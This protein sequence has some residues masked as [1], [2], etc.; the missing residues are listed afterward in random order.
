MVN[1]DHVPHAK[2]KRVGVYGAAGHTAKLVA[3][4]LLRRGLTPVLG[5]RD[6]ARLAAA[7]RELQDAE[8]R[9]AHVERPDEM[10]LFLN[11]CDA[12][13]NCGAV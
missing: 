1:Q 4:E 13:V 6:A 5:G 9:V 10:K 2:T 7:S 11:G 3:A 8:I 12:V